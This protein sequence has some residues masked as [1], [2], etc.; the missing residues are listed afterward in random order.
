MFP[1][2]RT[3]GYDAVRD[4]EEMV[5]RPQWLPQVNVAGQVDAA[6]IAGGIDPNNMPLRQI[7]NNGRVLGA[8]VNFD[9]PGQAWNVYQPPQQESESPQY[10][11][12][13]RNQVGGPIR[14]D[15]PQGFQYGFAPSGTESSLSS[16]PTIDGQT[17][18]QW[19]VNDPDLAEF[20]RVRRQQDGYNPQL[21]I[22]QWRQGARLSP[23]NANH[24]APYSAVPP[25]FPPDPSFMPQSMAG[26]LPGLMAP[27]P[28]PQ[29]VSFPGSI[30][31]APQCGPLSGP[32]AQAPSWLF[33][34]HMPKALSGTSSG[35]NQPR[36][37]PGLMTGSLRGPSLPP[38]ENSEESFLLTRHR[39]MPETIVPSY[40]MYPDAGFQSPE[41]PQQWNAPQGQN[42]WPPPVDPYAAPHWPS[43]IPIPHPDTMGFGAHLPPYGGVGAP[44]PVQFPPT[45]PPPP[46]GPAM[47][48]FPS[49]E[50]LHQMH[51]RLST[52]VSQWPRD[53]SDSPLGIGNSAPNGDLSSYHALTEQV[54]LLE[55][56]HQFGGTSIQ[57]LQTLVGLLTD[58]R[59]EIQQHLDEA[60]ARIAWCDETHTIH[61]EYRIICVNIR[62]FLEEVIQTVQRLIQEQQDT[63]ATMTRAWNPP[64]QYG[65]AVD[66]FGGPPFMPSENYAAEGSFAQDTSIGSNNGGVALLPNDLL[67]SSVPSAS[68]EAQLSGEQQALP[69]SDEHSSHPHHSEVDSYRQPFP[70]KFSAPEDPSDLQL[71]YN[72]YDGDVTKMNQDETVA[73]DVDTAMDLDTAMEA[74]LE[75][76]KDETTALG[77]KKDEGGANDA[78]SESSEEWEIHLS[79]QQHPPVFPA[80]PFSTIRSVSLPVSL[81]R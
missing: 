73:M 56:G 3:M 69:A 29:T 57:D 11:C 68:G 39:H 50:P 55:L 36:Q 65:H 37:S 27:P 66:S 75:A 79:P 58:N 19:E 13:D 18:H 30:A 9:A 62:N 10:L 40:G 21:A 71:D 34:M 63:R 15:V 43:N 54:S 22:D 32:L 80:N 5:E 24:G 12:G 60:N 42:I 72:Q 49:L 14:S 28:R 67:E 26:P 47:A 77:G 16:L 20:M 44:T 70:S 53:A 23:Q 38:F 46:Y 59:K 2:E 51:L 33:S 76:K 17:L 35:G 64:P 61:R 7:P 74:A 4:P 78:A 41:M 31:G 25:Y 1:S 48:P 6:L 45:S 52:L 8:S 81:E